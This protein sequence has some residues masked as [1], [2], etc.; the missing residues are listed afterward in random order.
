[1]T[2]KL[3]RATQNAPIVHTARSLGKSPAS[4]SRPHFCFTAH[5]LLLFLRDALAPCSICFG[6]LARL[7][8]A[9]LLLSAFALGILRNGCLAGSSAAPKLRPGRFARL[10][11]AWLLL[12][13]RRAPIR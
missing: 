4:S 5:P 13:T 1:M 11:W 3:S 2:N 7:A 6:P 8:G 12:A 10:H 9:S